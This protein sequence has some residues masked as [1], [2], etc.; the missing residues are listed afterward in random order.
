[1]TLLLTLLMGSGAMVYCI[2]PGDHVAIE[3]AHAVQQ[4]EY[5]ANAEPESL[6]VQSGWTFATDATCFDQP[7]LEEALFITS[8]NTM[9]LLPALSLTMLY[10]L[11]ELKQLDADHAFEQFDDLPAHPDL[12]VV[13]AVVLLI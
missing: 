10:E 3:W 4:C 6:P 11:P 7:V 13:Q 5:A 1:M 2:E 8:N 12:P 9:A